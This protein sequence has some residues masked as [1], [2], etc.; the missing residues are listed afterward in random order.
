MN[1]INLVCWVSC[2]LLLTGC[3]SGVERDNRESGQVHPLEKPV[4]LEKVNQ[5]LVRKSQRQIEGYI[6]R[7]RLAMKE[8][9]TGLWY[10]VV[11]NGLGPAITKDNWVTLHFQVNLL[12]GTPCYS[13]ADNGPKSFRVGHGGVETGLEEGILLLHEGDS[14]VF[15]LPPH[16]AHG[17]VGDGQRIPARAS[18]VYRLRVLTVQ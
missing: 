18:L 17:L 10:D 2:I 14:A 9:G 7:N 6:R 4:N 1:N 8:T 15:I 3:R 16:L 13:S 12:D 11:D 5:Y